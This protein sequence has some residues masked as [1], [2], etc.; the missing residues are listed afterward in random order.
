[1]GNSFISDRNN[2]FP[3]E[4]KGAF[5]SVLLEKFGQTLILIFL[6]GDHEYGHDLVEMTLIY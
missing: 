5:D 1:M 6:H 2:I 4:E 3:S